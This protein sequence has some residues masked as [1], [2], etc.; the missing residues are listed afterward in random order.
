LILA[1]V[2]MSKVWQDVRYALRSL[3]KSPGFT[4]IA[5]LTL[6]LGIGANTAIFS[7]VYGALLSPLPYPEPD[8]LV[9]VW[10]TVRGNNNSV[11]AGDYLDWKRE[12]SAFQDLLAFTGGSFSLSGSGKPEVVQTRIL[13]PGWFNLQGI[14]FFLGRDFRADEGTV[15]Q[16][17]VVVMT[18][19]FW[20]ERFGGDPRIIGHE[21]RLDGHPYS[22]IGV[23]AAGMPDRFE[24][25]LFVPLAFKPEQINH[26]FHWLN[27]L[28]RLKRGVTL[29]QANADM[30][31]VA[32]RVAETYPLS[33]KGWGVAV[34]PLKNDFTSRDTIKDLWLLTGAVGFVLL[35]ACVNVANL[36]LARGTIRQK[37]VAVRA[38]L[39]ATRGQLFSQFL[40][41]GLVLAIIGGT[42]GITL[43]TLILRVILILLPQYS[44]P[45]EA[46]IRINL[47]VLFFSLAAT[48]IAG[49]LSGCAPAWRISQQNLNNA[50]KEGGRS[51]ANI[52]RHGM[53]RWLVVLEFA[54]ALTLLAGAGLAIHSFWKLTRADLGF[55]PD[56]VLTSY[57][58]IPVERLSQPKQI[59][60]FYRQ[61]LAKVSSLPGVASA[62]V[63]TGAP[64]AGTNDSM[65]F[66]VAGQPVNDPASRP[67][68]GF[69]MVSPDYFRTFGI[70]IA[71]GRGFT[72]RDVE[73]G[74]PV[75]VVNETFARK[76]LAGLDPLRQ[77][78]VVEQLIPGANRL[79][80]PMEWQIV[81]VS[82]DIRNDSVRRESS[83]EIDVPFWQSPWPSARIELRT[84]GDPA[85][86]ANSLAI[87][88]QSME[89]DLAMYQ[90]RTMDQIVGESLAGDRFAASLFAAFAAVALILA[91]IGIYGVMSFAVAQRTH[92]IGLRMALG[93]AQGQ[94]LEMVFR[95]GMLL[96]GGGLLL[97]L[98]GTYA[99][100]R[101]MKSVLYGISAIDPL[102]IGVVA[103]ILVLSAALAC[104]LP[105]R[106]ATRVDP[107]VALRHE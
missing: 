12:N 102:A 27:V 85:S 32:E 61:L 81:G 104:Y 96:A 31:G 38:S 48:V 8:Q 3:A 49:L 93:A 89:T 73:D 39:G 13:S 54:L 52:G 76:Y 84:S 92:E 9:M 41:E 34:E 60:A 45:T 87:A 40:T 91:A 53:R 69:A 1:W 26:D 78:L 62:A 65:P 94:V 44:L 86:A 42:L 36:L 71:A 10:S 67:S 100:G 80:P 106:R 70:A 68:A 11:S 75:A 43:A 79:G 72:E 57:L 99:V 55:R 20:K 97:G 22:V 24:S 14:P 6:A 66:T 58:P 77:R 46:D 59:I 25:Q 33:N 74:L 30:K 7:V 63:S 105:A 98:T 64:I 101:T 19:Q 82:R 4:A 50:L 2:Q 35:I 21:L 56:H 29:Q 37:E 83:P 15:G 88:V 103:G 107:L 47:P 18:H 17:Q 95:E 23:L 28:G 51:V 5:V 16:D 90:V